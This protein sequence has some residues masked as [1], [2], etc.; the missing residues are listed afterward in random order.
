MGRIFALRAVCVAATI[1][2][3]GV[4]APPSPMKLLQECSSAP[5]ACTAQ[6]F[7]LAARSLSAAQAQ[8]P[9]GRQEAYRLSGTWRGSYMCAQ[10]LTGLTLTIEPGANGL[11]AV[12]E[13]YPVAENP[14]VP[15]GRFRMEGFFD[16]TQRT[17]TLQP[18]EWIDQPP[19]YLTVG[20]EARVDLDWG[21]ILGRI[22]ETPGCTW[23]RL[24]RQR[25]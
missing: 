7:K 14:L 5:L 3:A 4:F 25:Y 17:L 18:R 2:G 23:F 8:A 10:G 19:G 11:T 15:T 24:S 22:T 12:F 9:D 13:F 20:L 6:V 16:G 1:I 21:V